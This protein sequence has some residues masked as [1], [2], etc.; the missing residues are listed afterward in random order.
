MHWW[1]VQPKPYLSQKIHTTLDNAITSC[2]CK[3]YCLS[4]CT[5]PKCRFW[6]WGSTLVNRIR[7]CDISC[8]RCYGT[9]LVSVHFL[10]CI[11]MVLCFNAFQAES[12]QQELESCKEKLEEL[13][14]E[15][16]LLRGEISEKGESACIQ[17][18][19]TLDSEKKCISFVSFCLF[20]CCFRV[21][22]FLFVFCCYGVFFVFFGIMYVFISLSYFVQDS[23]V[24]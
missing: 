23:K 4:N 19:T 1:P 9:L 22:E 8:F 2:V 11:K 10:S 3:S 6:V 15:L 5:A 7:N 12:L 13:T 20:C 17:W 14:L 18:Y 24:C 16:E 21:V